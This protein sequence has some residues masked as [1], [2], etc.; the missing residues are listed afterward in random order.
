M[1]CCQPEPYTVLH[2]LQGL[3]CPALGSTAAAANLHAR[4]EDQLSLRV[5]PRPQVAHRF[6]LSA[7]HAT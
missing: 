1:S 3:N 2:R 6:S 4:F 5:S 7:A